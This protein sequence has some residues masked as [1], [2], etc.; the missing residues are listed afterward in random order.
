MT[1]HKSLK[2]T[3]RNQ[4]WSNFSPK[5]RMETGVDHIPYRKELMHER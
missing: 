1:A 2:P 3:L 5:N 4:L